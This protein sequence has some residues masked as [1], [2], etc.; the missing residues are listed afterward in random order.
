MGAEPAGPLAVGLAGEQFGEPLGP[1][2]WVFTRLGQW[3]MPPVGA[4]LRK[5]RVLSSVKPLSAESSTG[6]CHQPV[7]TCCGQVAALLMSTG[8]CAAFSWPGWDRIWG[9]VPAGPV[10]VGNAV[11]A[12]G[13]GC[14]RDQS[15]RWLLLSRRCASPVAAGARPYPHFLATYFTEGESGNRRVHAV[16]A[17]TQAVQLPCL[18]PFALARELLGVGGSM[19]WFGRPSRRKSWLLTR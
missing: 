7:R 3:A 13:K 16:L 18:V 17:S 4:P 6:C 10:L 12:N 2:V 19:S 9:P 11:L 15:G 1:D 5:E 8:G 14:Y